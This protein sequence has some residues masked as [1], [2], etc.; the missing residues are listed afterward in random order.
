M[1][2]ASPKYWLNEV[3]RERTSFTRSPRLSEET[4]FCLIHTGVATRAHID[5]VQIDETSL[6]T[7][8]KLI[9]S[10]YATSWSDVV[11]EPSHV[12]CIF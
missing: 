3:I 1:I 10:Q 4:P 9:K 7:V 6:K 12:H 2:P 5:P 11:W 8:T